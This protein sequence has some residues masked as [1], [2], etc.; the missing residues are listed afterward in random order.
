M[1]TLP[2]VEPRHPPAYDFN[3]HVPA[4]AAFGW[5]AA[6]WRDFW[7]NPLA[8]LLYGLLVAA[9][10]AG[11]VWGLFAL[12]LDYILFPALSAFLVVGPVLAIGLYEKSRRI[13]AGEKAR[14]ARMI[15]VRAQ[16]GYQVIF[17]GG[18]ALEPS[19]PPLDARGRHRL[20]A[21]LRRAGVS[22]H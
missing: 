19:R 17:A 11:I 10:S 9:I 15:F 4:S 20:C 8:S 22:W 21:L 2:A 13:A 16:S 18:R 6:G 12:Q 5:L 1:S 14:F 3:R 7:K